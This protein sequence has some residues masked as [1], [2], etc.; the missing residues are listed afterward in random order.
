MEEGES[1]SVRSMMFAELTRATGSLQW[2][3]A[4]ENVQS[5]AWLA[6]LATACMEMWAAGSV[7]KSTFANAGAATAFGCTAPV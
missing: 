2:T 6:S 1:I 7:I 4:F 5:D 3:M